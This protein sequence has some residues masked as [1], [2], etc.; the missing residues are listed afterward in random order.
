VNSAIYRGWIRHRRREPVRNS[1]RYSAFL[2]Y[3]DLAELP[4]VFRGRWLWSAGR[5]APAWFRRQ[6][7]WGD[8][9][10]PLAESVSALV[11]E[12]TGRP[13]RGP[14]RLLTH[15]RYFG[16]VFNPVSFY[17]CFDPDG[18]RIETV[19]AEVTNT[20][21]HETHCY[22]LPVEESTGSGER[23]RFRFAKDFHVSPFMAMD[24]DYDWRFTAPGRRLAVHMDNVQDGRRIFDATMVMER[25]PIRTTELA[26]CLVS[27]PFMT[28]KVF[29]AIHWQALRLWWK[30]VP[31]H[32]HPRDLRA[33]RSS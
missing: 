20:P 12:R 4:T 19:V 26:R 32:P 27:Y 15:L 17:Y 25:R 7:H 30:R 23:L 33:S 10:R 29:A 1:F 24:I 11:Q 3:L 2:L 6:D 14:I 22:V 9:S 5:P 13:V 31:V 21:W 8:P 16:Y 18:T 28:G